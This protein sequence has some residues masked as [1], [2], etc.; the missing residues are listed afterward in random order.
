M[1]KNKNGSGD[2]IGGGAGGDGSIL[3][4]DHV[5]KDLR[6]SK[7][8]TQTIIPDLSVAIRPG[9]FLTITGPSGSGKSTL[10]YMMGGLDLPTSGTIVFDGDTISGMKEDQLVKLRNRKVGFIY[11]FH[12]LLPEFSALENVT[13]PMLVAGTARKEARERGEHLLEKVGMKEK[14]GSR[15]NQLSGGQQQRVAVARA[16]ANKPLLLLGDEPTGSLDT[17]S[18][19]QVYDLMHELNQEGQTIIYV[20][21]DALL[22]AR[23]RRRINLVDGRIELDETLSAD[24]APA[25]IDG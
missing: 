6:S 9:E 23:A 16:L 4:L 22:A 7:E 8:V 17:K 3:R 5:R 18:T 11:Q 19:E 2:G 15:P 12:F 24:P 13:M 20:T 14:L 25:T 21:H 1:S 10:L